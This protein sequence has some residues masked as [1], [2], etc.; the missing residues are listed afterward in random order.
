MPPPLWLKQYDEVLPGAA[1][2]IITVFEKQVDHRID[3]EKTVISSDK[4][5]SK[6]GVKLGFVLQLVA[7]LAG[8]IVILFGKELAG[9]SV[10]GTAFATMIANFIIQISKRGQPYQKRKN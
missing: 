10:V 1:E 8:V 6:L 2:R 9:F 7:I 4:Q 3:L 5:N